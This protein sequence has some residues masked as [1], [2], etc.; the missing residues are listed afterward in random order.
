[1]VIGKRNRYGQLHYDITLPITIETDITTMEIEIDDVKI[2]HSPSRPMPH[3]QD[4]NNPAYYD[5]GDP[6][7]TELN[8]PDVVVKEIR[9]Q[10]NTEVHNLRIKLEQQIDNIGEINLSELLPEDQNE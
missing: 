6:E 5:P 4:P 7:E 1:M 10:F 3:C 2:N 8:D 9:N